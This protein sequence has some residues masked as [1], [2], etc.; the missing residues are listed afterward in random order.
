MKIITLNVNKISSGEY[1]HFF[2]HVSSERQEKAR[3]FHFDRDAYCCVF[4]E[5]LL[6]YAVEETFDQ[7]INLDIDHND[8]GKPFINGLD[9]FHFNI[10]H[11]G[12]WVI[13]AY[14]NSEVGVDIEEIKEKESSVLDNILSKEEMDYVHADE[15]LMNK[16]FIKIWGIKESYIKY[17]GTG[18]STDIKSVIVKIPEFSVMDKNGSVS[19]DVYTQSILF[20]QNYYLTVCSK[21]KRLNIKELTIKDLH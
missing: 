1:E 14:G 4:A 17:L 16:R 9:D 11:S 2:N 21:D 19:D 5:V 6:R 15:R 18:L 20:N 12:D 3:R 8:Y 7:D 10:S 13:L